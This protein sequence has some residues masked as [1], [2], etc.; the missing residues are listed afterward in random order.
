MNKSPAYVPGFKHDIFISYAHVDNLPSQGG[1]RWVDQFHRAFENKL[2]TRVGRLGSVRIWRDPALDGSQVFDQALRNRIQSAAVFLALTSNGYL[3]SDYCVKELHWFHQ[4][5]QQSR[6]GLQIG[7]RRRLLN[8]LLTNLH[9]T[10]WPEEFRGTTGFPFH[11][12]AVEDQI[13]EPTKPAS[14]DFDGQIRKLADAAYRLLEDFKK[15]HEMAPEEPSSTSYI[16][17]ADTSDSLQEVR[18]RLTFDLKQKGTEVITDIPPPYEPKEH[19]ASVKG[20]L[21]KARLSVHLLDA[22]PGRKIPEEP[23]TTYPKRQIE[24]ALASS[25]PQLLWVAPSLSLESVSSETHRAFLKN[26]ESGER[27]QKSYD[28]VRE[29]AE[30]LVEVILGKLERLETAIATTEDASSILLDT[31]VKDQSFAWDLGRYLVARG[32]QP[33]IHPETDDPEAGIRAF[34]DQLARVR[35]L[36]V[37]YGHVSRRWVESRIECA[38]QFVARQLVSARR[39]TL[40]ACYVYLLPPEKRER[41]AFGPGI[42]RIEI[43]D[44]SGSDQLRPETVTPLLMARASGSAS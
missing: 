38:L 1:A 42:F 22:F 16:F 25:K 43:L 24:L 18:E 26:L 17:L 8:A 13:A 37:F 32:I 44:N 23:D 21:K 14:D 34:E 31:H 39:S 10:K 41:F 29:P 2:A 3:E 33:F 19:E 40:E 9:H 28:F 7:E 4:T 36:V 20:A 30:R 15:R 11:D 5:A 27:E 6:D 35:K 12:A